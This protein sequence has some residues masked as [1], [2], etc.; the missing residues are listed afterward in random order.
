M[1]VALLVKI[2]AP[3][4]PFL[5]ALGGKAVDKAAEKVGEKSVEGLLP[6]AGKLW[7][8][9]YPKVKAK[10]AAREA[11]EEVAKN[12]DDADA[13]A[14]L[15][16]QLKK[17]LEAPENADL[18]AEIAKILGEEESSV[19]TAKYDVDVRDSN[20]GAV[21]DRNTITMTFGTKSQE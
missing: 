20:V 5:I 1:D 18:A 13:V 21:G 6:K 19:S 12:P 4:L 7:E 11:S 9:L 8:K 15:R 16:Q 3:C 10:E 14:A 2:L 17:I